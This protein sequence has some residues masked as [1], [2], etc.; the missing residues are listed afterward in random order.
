MKSTL[1][2]QTKYAEFLWKA[3]AR[4]DKKR[5]A[6]IPEPLDVIQVVNVQY[7]PSD[8]EED[9][10][11]HLTDIYYPQSST[12]TSY[13]VIV[14]VHGGGWFYG[15]KETYA[16]YTKYLAGKGFAVVNFNYRLSPKNKYPTGFSDVCKLMQFLLENGKRFHLDLSHVAMIGDS[17]GAQLGL[18][19]AVFASNEQYRLLFPDFADIPVLTPTKLVLNCGKF[20]VEK[21]GRNET[22]DWYLPEIMTDA[23]TESLAHM[24]DYITPDFPSTFLMTSVND[25]L[26]PET[27]QLDQVLTDKQITH[28]YKEYGQNDPK[29]SHVFHLNLLNDEAK[30]CNQA[31]ISFIREDDSVSKG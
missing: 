19:Y 29:N 17:S 7:A 22:S 31:E 25:S 8:A 5:D 30:Q 16:T 6:A 1:E 27:Q 14:N 12:D 28:V 11:W 3:W 24:N 4:S 26:Y 15:T 20:V 10:V 9:T 21:T 18:Q 2:K 23:Q 13:P